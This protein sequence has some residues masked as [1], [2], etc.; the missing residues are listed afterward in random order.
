VQT[1]TSASDTDV[2]TLTHTPAAVAHAVIA[3]GS[4]NT[5]STTVSASLNFAKDDTNQTE[6]VREGVNA[7]AYLHAGVVQRQTLAAGSTSWKWRVRAETA[8][9]TVNVGNLAIAV[10]QLDA[11]PAARRCYMTVAG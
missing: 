6:F 4:F 10:L 5:A 1:T 11:T 7:A 2:L 3:I 9:T 8:G